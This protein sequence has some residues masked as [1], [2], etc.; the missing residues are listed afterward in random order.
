MRAIVSKQRLALFTTLVGG[1]GYLAFRSMDEKKRVQFKQNADAG[2]RIFNLVRTVAVITADYGWNIYFGQSESL[3]A[4]AQ[5]AS[6]EIDNLNAML[7]KLQ[8]DQEHFTKML[9][10]TND[11]TEKALWVEKIKAARVDIDRISEELAI[12]KEEY[13]HCFG[14]GRVHTRSAV[15]MRDM[16]A[17]NKGVYIKLGQHI[18]ML[19]Y[20]V[21]VEYTSALMTLLSQTS[22]SPWTAVDRVLRTEFGGK[23]MEFFD[24]I[25]KDPIASAS[26]AQVH[27][28]YGKDGKKYAV[29]VQHEGLYECSQADMLAITYIIDLVSRIF[30]DFNYKWLTA[31]MNRNIP[32]ELDFRIE[33]SN[34]AKCTECLA[35]LIRS[36]DVAVPRVI[37]ELSSNRVL[38][39]SFE[40]GAFV[41]DLDAIARMGAQR[42]DVARIVSRT[43]CEQM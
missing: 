24:R 26:L 31:E 17:S 42:D 10:A 3:S 25:E 23:H 33:A 21:P 8:S 20:M 22:H 38:T 2:V 37:P 13:R 15:R 7:R 12:L 36:G 5:R 19:D 18:A 35:D 29:K 1:T 6:E 32:L 9:W 27:V 28:A 30:K 4:E 39:M 16:C 14:I 43:F 34:V 40:E 41:N 11:N